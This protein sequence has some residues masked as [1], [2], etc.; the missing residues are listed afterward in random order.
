MNPQ[1]Q[2]VF[3]LKNYFSIPCFYDSHLHFEGIGKYLAKNNLNQ[4]STLQ[5]LNN[6]I[7]NLKSDHNSNSK[8]FIEGFGLKKT[9]TQNL[10]ILDDLFNQIQSSSNFYFVLEDGHQL[11]V[12]GPI[13]NLFFQ[14]LK[15]KNIKITYNSNQFLDET[16]FNYYQS[17]CLFN[18]E[19]RKHFDEF[20]NDLNLKDLNNHDDHKTTESHLL[21][22]QTT[23]LKSG[24][25]HF[26][27]LTSDLNQLTS[28]LS[29]EKTK[30]LTVF[31]ETF[32]SDFSGQNVDQL[33]KDS[34]EAKNILLHKKSKVI[35]RGI[36]I[37]LDG[38]FSQCTVDT[39]PLECKSKYSVN[40]IKDLLLLAS[41]QDLE[42]SFHTIGDLAVEKV[43][44]SFFIVKDLFKTQ[45]H[46]EHCELINTETLQ[47]LKK[48]RL[49]DKSKIT[50]HFQPSHYLM[51]QIQLNHI[52]SNKK[53][54]QILAW[55]DLHHSGFKIF[56]GSD[57]PVSPPG[58]N[59]LEDL[60]LE[61]FFISHYSKAPFWSFF[62]HPE[63]KIHPETYTLF[64]GHHV[65]SVF[66]SGQKII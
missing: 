61:P 41:N 32:Y 42:I 17:T 53:E 58:L 37:F 36:K 28:L 57:A 31:P 21:L 48:L 30:Q 15:Y 19:H 10:K 14:N 47:I 50:F 43:I 26:R 35:H 46:L 7:R 66:I 59:Y 39:N 18:D 63:Y 40:E 1:E 5:D 62:N 24:V 34:T 60:V 51:D 13:L 64:K 44:K 12:H 2:K 3:K 20:Y 38:T 49:L 45:L 52:K 4:I 65:Q 54:I 9:L 29:L 6:Y 23:L 8:S 22:A 56:F 27:D 16:Q 55:P 11:L 25:T 33:I